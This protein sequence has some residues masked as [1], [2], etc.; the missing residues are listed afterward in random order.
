[1][2]KHSF[3]AFELALLA[4]HEFFRNKAKI[5]VKIKQILEELYQRLEAE[6]ALQPLLA[7]EG[8]DS[9]SRQFVKGEHLEDFPYQYVDFPRWYT[10]ETKFAFRSLI[11]WGHHIVFALI[12]EGQLVKQYRRNLFNRYSEVADRNLCLCLSPSLWEWKA[13]PGLTI[14]ITHD[15][16]SEIA[17]TLDHRTF[18][19]IARF[20][21]LDD[22]AVETGTIVDEG[23]KAFQAILPVITT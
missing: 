23:L 18:F 17:A 13:G 19:K 4:D 15:G 1:M 20:L 5:S 3:T 12:V 2:T 14:P 8:F 9:Q 10:R 7:P 16:R 6:I 21:P 22:P 11:W